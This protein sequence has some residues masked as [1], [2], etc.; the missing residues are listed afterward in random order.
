MVGGRVAARR[1]VMVVMNSRNSSSL[2]G[3][4]N[5]TYYTTAAAASEPVGPRHVLLE[6]VPA[7]RF[8]RSI[9]QQRE[10]PGLFFTQLSKTLLFMF[11]LMI[12]L[13]S[14]SSCMLLSTIHFVVILQY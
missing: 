13:C 3:R 2:L 4:S 5:R 12:F 6:I 10:E 14:S 11:G 8:F 9:D 1:V 7:V